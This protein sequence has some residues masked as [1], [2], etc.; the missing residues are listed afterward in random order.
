[1]PC[2]V[3]PQPGKPEVRRVR[4]TPTE[5]GAYV[6]NVSYDGHPIAG[7]PFPVEG[8]LPPDPSKVL[9]FYHVDKNV[10]PLCFSGHL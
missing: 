2:K 1:M 8:L 7:S 6:I 5:E 9:T 4:Y 3:E 10:P